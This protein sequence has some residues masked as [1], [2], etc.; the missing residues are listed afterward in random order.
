MATIRRNIKAGSKIVRGAQD[1]RLDRTELPFYASGY[2]N[3]MTGM[4]AAIDAV[5][6]DAGGWQARAP[7]YTGLRGP[8]LHVVD[9]EW[10]G[11]GQVFGSLVYARGAAD[12][13]PKRAS[14][15]IGF[16]ETNG[17]EGTHIDDL[18]SG[19]VCNEFNITTFVKRRA[20]IEHIALP[21]VWKG[22]RPS[23]PTSTQVIN[24]ASYTIDGISYPAFTLRFDGY[25]YEAYEARGTGHYKGTINWSYLA[26]GWKGHKIICVKWKYLPLEGDQTLPSVG[27]EIDAIQLYLYPTATFASIAAQCPFCF[28]ANSSG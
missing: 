20:A 28:G 4:E 26:G 25:Q 17:T 24:D 23:P 15:T 13:S 5:V 11:E 14:A 22:T 6:S 3:T 19:N 10:F 8:R 1:L 18:S 12:C 21:C 9:A 7:G 27:L 16:I 2:S